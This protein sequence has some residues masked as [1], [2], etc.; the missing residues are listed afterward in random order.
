MD[1]P[2]NELLQAVEALRGDV[3][4][5]GSAV[6]TLGTEASARHVEMVGLIAD[7]RGRLVVID[8]RHR[9]VLCDG[10]VGPCAGHRGARVSEHQ[11][12]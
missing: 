12:S 6:G 4:A 3:A 10:A 11:A 5:L 1:N 8:A 9:G 2:K 7:V